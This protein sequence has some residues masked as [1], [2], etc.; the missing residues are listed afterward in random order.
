MFLKKQ[1]I[2]SMLA[3]YNCMLAEGNRKHSVFLPVRMGRIK[4]KGRKGKKIRK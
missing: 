2:L 1:V 4:E 3:V